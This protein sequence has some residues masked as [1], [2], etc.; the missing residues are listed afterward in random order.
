MESSTHKKTS[1]QPRVLPSRTEPMARGFVRFIGGPP[2]AHALIGRAKWWTPLR[3]LLATAATFLA[4]GWLQK[5]QCI[6]T[7]FTSAGEAY[8]DW[9]GKRQYTSACYSDTISL[10]SGRGLDNLDFPY[11]TSITGSDGSVHYM[12]Y[13]VLTGLYQWIVAAIARPVG[14]LWDF[15]PLPLATPVAIFFGVNAFFLG[16]FWLVATGLMTKLTGNRVWDTLLMA[17]SPLVIV[18]AFTNFDLLAC[19]AA[20]AIFSLWAN[21]RPGW[22]GVA[23]GV[24]VALKLWPAF[25]GGALILLCLRQRAWGPLAKLV[26]G[27]L[28][29]WLIVNVPIMVAAPEG[30]GE[31]F[32]LNSERGWE[33]STIYAVIAHI[34][35]NDSWNG[36]SPSKSVDGAETLNLLTSGLLLVALLG[37][38]WLVIIAAPRTPRVGQVA[39]LATLAFMITNK[40]WSPQYSIWLV[41]LLVLALPRWRLVFSWAALE[42]VYWYLRMWQFLPANQAAPNWLVDTVTVV[43]LALLVFMAVLVIRQIMGRSADP[44]REAHGGRDPLAGV[45]AADVPTGKH[46]RHGNGS[47][48]KVGVIKK[49]TTTTAAKESN[50]G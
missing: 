18:H 22:A 46:H 44:I 23:V 3:V 50:D 41:P 1:S 21:R 16:L 9:S 11:F 28:G 17:A 15:L 42:A 4:F 7:G 35:G 27:T 20:V 49:T 13:P 10:Y 24:G 25:I 12:E 45:L 29:T 31:F 36:V 30:W 37:L 33:G 38:A 43:R 48:G 14:V 34:T 40:V 26:G 2:G 5:A 39:F 19:A 32:R 47:G 8:V 6:R